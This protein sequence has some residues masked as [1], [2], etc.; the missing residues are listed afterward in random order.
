[1]FNTM[2]IKTKIVSITILGLLLLSGILGTISI[3]QATEALVK[4]SYD[5]L[6]SAR[7]SKAEQ[8]QKFFEER[9]GDIQVLS[10]SADIQNLNNEL[11]RVY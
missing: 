11:L 3:Q 9:V 6:T 4:K 2:T 5:G 7:D 1:M 10:K 8:I